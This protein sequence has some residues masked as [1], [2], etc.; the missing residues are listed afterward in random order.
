MGMGSGIDHHSPEAELAQEM[1]AVTS[2][3]LSGQRL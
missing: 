3:R 2:Q 1:A